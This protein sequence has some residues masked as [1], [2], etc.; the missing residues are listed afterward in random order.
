MFRPSRRPTR[1]LACGFTLIDLLVSLLVVGVLATIAT[2]SFTAPLYQARRTDALNA[3][4]QLQQAQERWHAQ[5][6]RYASLSE[7]AST[8][9]SPQGLYRVELSELSSHGYQMVAI[10]QGRQAGDAGCERLPAR[11]RHGQ[12]ELGGGAANA[13]EARRC[14]RV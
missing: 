12:L 9:V 5:H 11:V 7:L 2:P 14:W 1:H 6:S 10:A 8:G 4:I 3:V 13:A